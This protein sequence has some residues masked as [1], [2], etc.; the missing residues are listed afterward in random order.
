[1][2]F[3]TPFVVAIFNVFFASFFIWATKYE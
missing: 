2:I 1:M 3:T